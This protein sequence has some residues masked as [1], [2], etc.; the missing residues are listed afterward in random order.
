MSDNAI[1]SR[2]WVLCGLPFYTGNFGDATPPS[3]KRTGFCVAGVQIRL[4]DG[5]LHL[6]GDINESGGECECCGT[7]RNDTIIEAYRVLLTEKELK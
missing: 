1:V 4:R 5:S 2:E 6:I 7:I 3:F